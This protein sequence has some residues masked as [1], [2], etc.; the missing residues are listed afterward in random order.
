MKAFLKLIDWYNRNKRDLPW[1]QTSDPYLIW[2]SEVILQQT[3]VEQGLPYY[4][5]FAKQYPT[6]KSL[7]KANDDEVMKMWQGLG[8]YNRA[9]NMLRTAREV[10]QSYDGIFPENYDG[11]ITLKGIGPYT[12]AAIASFAFNEAKA[13]VDGN[14]NRVLARYF[15]IEEPINSS[16]G[17]TLFT[18][19][20]NNVLHKKEPATHNQAMM[21]LGAMVCKPANPQCKA[22]VLQDT[23][24]AYANSSVSQYPVKLKKQAPKVRHLHYLVVNQAGHTYV[25]QR[26]I[27]RIWHN[28]YEPPCI[29]TTAEDKVW[30]DPNAQL[31][32]T[33]HSNITASFKCKHQ[34][35]HQTIYATFWVI[36]VK[37]G[38]KFPLEGFEKIRISDLHTLAVHRL[39]DK[40]L[41]L[42]ILQLQAV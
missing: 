7:A 30:L 40:F 38:Y 6:V 5:N 9:K 26:K 27:E 28:L 39:F 37:R 22:C 33:N 41:Q 10:V 15:G 4:L 29:E 18:Q 35:T 20:A 42:H 14:V 21:E 3:R 34:L 11:L 36:E 24:L 17:K 1:R 19:L 12:A 16:A 8:Y 31:I 2:L 13:V 32:A 25:K 23:C